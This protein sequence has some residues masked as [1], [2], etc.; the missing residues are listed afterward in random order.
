MLDVERF[1]LLHGPY[2]MPRCRIGKRLVCKVRGEVIVCA[3]SA[4]RIPWPIGKRG[5]AKALVVC[6]DLARAVRRESN[7]AVSYWWGITGQTVTIWRKALGVPQVNEGT[8]RLYVDYAPER[9]TEEVRQQATAK[10][11]SPEANAK[12]GACWRGQ[13]KPAHVLEALR[14]ANVGRKLTEEHKAKIGAG[15]RRGGHRPPKGKVWEPWEL[16]LVGTL[17][18]EEVAERTGRSVLA[19]SGKRCLLRLEKP[20]RRGRRLAREGTG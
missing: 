8:A 16:A 20:D 17:P 7:L 1:K 9:L 15:L 13:P 19:V 2:R 14:R 6:G 18:D 11:N 12:K 3:I 10:A 5:R 4:G